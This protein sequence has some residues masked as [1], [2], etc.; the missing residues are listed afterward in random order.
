M[1]KIILILML[2]S[3]SVIA[4]ETVTINNAAPI[5]TMADLKPGDELL[6]T[7]NDET[8]S[9]AI[10]KDICYVFTPEGFESRAMIS[11]ILNDDN[12]TDYKKTFL[13]DKTPV[14]SIKMLTGN[15]CGADAQRIYL[16]PKT[17][18]LGLLTQLDNMMNAEDDA[19][20]ANRAFAD[21]YTRAEEVRKELAEIRRIIK[22]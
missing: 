6:V 22:D 14:Q 8:F 10:F 7:N 5:V 11:S 13:P 1:K 17:Q 3:L 9:H 21:L 19:A 4:D 20:K 16:V 18:L 15:V 12:I 2:F